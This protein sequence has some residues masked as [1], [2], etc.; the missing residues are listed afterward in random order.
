MITDYQV[1]IHRICRT[2][3]G[4]GG[5]CERVHVED[6]KKNVNNVMVTWEGYVTYDM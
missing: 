4:V 5:R 1:L 6:V 3:E 2:C